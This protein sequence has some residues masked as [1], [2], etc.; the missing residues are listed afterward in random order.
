MNTTAQSIEN[1]EKKD[2]LLHVAFIGSMQENNFV[3]VNCSAQLFIGSFFTEFSAIN[4]ANRYSCCICF[5]RA[6]GY[7]FEA[8]TGLNKCNIHYSIRQVCQACRLRKCYFMGMKKMKQV[9]DI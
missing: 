5:A 9:N 2:A 7:H 3:E 1:V 8:Q 4:N 6:T